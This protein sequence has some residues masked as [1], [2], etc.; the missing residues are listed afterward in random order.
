[1]LPSAWHGLP[2]LSTS[3]EVPLLPGLLRC[4]CAD[5]CRICGGS[6]CCACAESIAARPV[7]YQVLPPAVF[8]TGSSTSSPVNRASAC[9]QPFVQAAGPD[10][11]KLFTNPTLAVTFLAPD[12]ANWLTCGGAARAAQRGWPRAPSQ[13]AAS[14]LP[15]VWPPASASLLT[16]AMYPFSGG[17]NG[18][19]HPT[20]PRFLRSWPTQASALG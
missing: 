16:T 10:V 11:I 20:R 4:A 1:M 19:S 12:N 14:L 15:A 2:A 8:R 17:P 13:P 6:T 7:R 18:R 5:V 3:A 9:I